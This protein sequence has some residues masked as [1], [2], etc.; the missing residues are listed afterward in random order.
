MR[1]EAVAPQMP[2]R[3][4]ASPGRYAIKMYERHATKLFL[5]R[6]D[7]DRIVRAAGQTGG[8]FVSL[9]V[10]Y[11][12]DGSGAAA[13]RPARDGETGRMADLM[14]R[15]GAARAVVT[16]C[17][18]ALARQ[19]GLTSSRDGDVVVKEDMLILVPP[20]A[21]EKGTRHDSRRKRE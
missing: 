19:L 4:G 16:L 17:G 3:S 8:R 12:A 20:A 11:D 7:V 6:S 5:S 2:R 18:T 1:W 21:E 13:T 9:V 10:M 14:T 15:K